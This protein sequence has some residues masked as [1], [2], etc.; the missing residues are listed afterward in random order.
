MFVS[1]RKQETSW[2]KE[3]TWRHSYR[4]YKIYIIFTF[5]LLLANCTKPS[6]LAKHTRQIIH[7]VFM[8][9]YNDYYCDHVLYAYFRFISRFALVFI[10]LGKNYFN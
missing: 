4:K 3:E 10:S 5:F 7:Q 2:K 8:F 1:T 6:A 9:F